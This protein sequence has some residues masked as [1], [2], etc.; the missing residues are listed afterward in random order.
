MELSLQIDREAAGAPA[1]PRPRRVLVGFAE[2]LATIESVWSLQDA[3]FEVSAFARAGARVPLRRSR[4]VELHELIAPEV[5]AAAAAAELRALIAASGVDAVMP[6]DDVALRLCQDACVEGGAILAGPSGRQAAVALDKRLQIEAARAAGL[7]VP[8]TAFLD[9]GPVPADLE[10]PLVVRPAAAV[11]EVGGHLGSASGASTCADRGELDRRLATRKAGEVLLAQPQLR[12]T[13]EGIFGLA[14]EEGV[15]AWSAHRRLRMMNPAGSGSSACE[16]TV[17]EEELRTKVERML[18]SIGWR[19]LFMVELLRDTDG[20]PWF[21]ELN[22]RAWGSMAL[23]RAA[24]LEYPAW[25]VR[26]ALG[27]DLGPLPA[28]APAA[29]TRARHLGRE[30]KHALIVLRGS[31]SVAVPWPS[32]TATLRDVFS[33][34]RGDRIY[35]W[36]GRA[37]DLPLLAADTATTL[38]RRRPAK[39][40]GP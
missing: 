40:D 9:G 22:G 19:G 8:P 5:D 27:D 33:W 29:G 30:L 21:I 1:P 4:S 37:A 32:R 13:N 3:G 35:N 36:S 15:R 2:A 31:P 11:E 18:A 39:G 34:R 6:L 23:A 38:R 17:P 26:A 24:G 16:S 14:G 12:G 10:F 7:A 28:V 20:T 25:S